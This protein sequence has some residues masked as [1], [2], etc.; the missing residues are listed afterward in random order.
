MSQSSAVYLATECLSA[1]VVTVLP[2]LH[3]NVEQTSV[4]SVGAG[5]WSIEFVTVYPEE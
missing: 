4:M 1:E 5:C 2:P 3:G